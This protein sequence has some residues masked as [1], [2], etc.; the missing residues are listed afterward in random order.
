[1]RRSEG[2]VDHSTL[3][4]TM[5]VELT[6]MKE[7]NDTSA[8]GWIKDGLLGLHSTLPQITGFGIYLQCGDEASR[9]DDR[10]HVEVRQGR[11]TSPALDR[12]LEGAHRGHDQ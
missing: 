2:R 5:D 10:V 7:R 9:G 4:Y 12:D 6:L 11:M 3:P 1:M 8:S